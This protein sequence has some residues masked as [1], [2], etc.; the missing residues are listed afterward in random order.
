MPTHSPKLIKESAQ[1]TI[2]ITCG[3]PAG[4]G[5]DIILQLIKK[6]ADYKT[7]NFVVIG[8]NDVI[9]KRAKQL[10]IKY[11]F[12]KYTN[13]HSNKQPI[14]I[15]DIPT[16]IATKTGLLN[17]ENSSHVI[18]CLDIATQ[19][20]LNN[21]FAAMVTGPV[22]KGIINDA[23]INFTGH[24]EYLA[25]KSQR[26]KVVMMLC[27]N[28]SAFKLR[29]A[30]VTTHLPLN[31]VSAAITPI[32]LEQTI[33]ILH[34]DLK[35]Y[36][37]ISSPTIY[38]CGLNP[39]AGE[40]G[41]LGIEEKT[42]IEPCLEKL[43]AVGLKLIGPLAA[44]TLFVADNLKKADAVIAMYHD[45]G[46]PMLKHLGFGQAINVTLG[47]PFV[48]TSVDHGTALELAGTGKAKATS[49]FNAIDLAIQ[50]INQEPAKKAFSESRQLS[51][52]E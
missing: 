14:E 16:N 13:N 5:A 6:D 37:N 44:D 34:H 32:E 48:R 46:L 9:H 4:I 23:G 27:E 39:H 25:K 24:T 28:N 35:H 30:L 15:L 19:G 26:K 41:H 49:L 51:H 11:P 7:I 3:E 43:R 40:N 12:K 33:K 42:I 52:A 21:T 45:Q 1:Q 2:A 17:K 10:E 22:H 50:M 36:F 29:V 20:C 47:L 38:V 18:E 8:N 31:K